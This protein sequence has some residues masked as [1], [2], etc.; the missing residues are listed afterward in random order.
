VDIATICSVIHW[1]FSPIDQFNEY[2]H[3]LIASLSFRVFSAIGVTRI[4]RKDDRT[5]V[6]RPPRIGNDDVRGVPHPRSR[7][8]C[9]PILVSPCQL[10]PFFFVS[11]RSCSPPRTLL[12]NAIHIH[13][14]RSEPKLIKRGRSAARGQ[15]SPLLRFFSIKILNSVFLPLPSLS[16]PPHYFDNSASRHQTLEQT[17]GERGK[18]ERRERR[19]RWRSELVTCPLPIG[20]TS[21]K[22]PLV[23]LRSF[24]LLISPRRG[25]YLFASGIY[26]EW[27]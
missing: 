9:P 21:R 23:A 18:E 8:H 4:L 27:S 10:L 5:R 14:S 26:F 13:A 22:R 12:S 20:C 6:E 11:P 2:R 19:K 17:N 3:C 24:T 7:R 25:R 16:R 1:K 15:A